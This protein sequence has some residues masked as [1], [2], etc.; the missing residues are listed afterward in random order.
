MRRFARLSRPP[1]V[2]PCHHASRVGLVKNGAKKPFLP[3]LISIIYLIFKKL[4]TNACGIFQSIFK[5]Q[6]VLKKMGTMN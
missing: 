5:I 2:R 3:R 4:F 1:T 6:K